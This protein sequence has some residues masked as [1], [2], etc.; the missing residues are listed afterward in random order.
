[1]V[2]G[3]KLITHW[4]IRTIVAEQRIVGKVNVH[5][6]LNKNGTLGSEFTYVGAT[7]TYLE[8]YVLVLLIHI[9]KEPLDQRFWLENQNTIPISLSFDFTTY[10]VGTRRKDDRGG[11]LKNT[12]WFNRT[13]YVEGKINKKIDKVLTKYFPVF[14]VPGVFAVDFVRLYKFI[15]EYNKPDEEIS[16]QQRLKMLHQQLE[17][18]LQQP[19]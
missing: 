3:E 4:I 6:L 13:K 14:I 1:L 9:L 19:E 16:R 12:L 2:Y 11:Y 17:R 7:D 15:S 5:L 18:M 8:A 10:S